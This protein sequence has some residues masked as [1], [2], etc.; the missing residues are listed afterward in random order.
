MS[1]FK[2]RTVCGILSLLLILG[3]L[4]VFLV[5][6]TGE[7]QGTG[8]ESTA[9][10]NQY[11]QGNGFF[12]YTETAFLFYAP[13]TPVQF[14]DTELTQPPE[15][16]CAKPNCRHNSV[17]CSAYVDTTGLYAYNNRLYYVTKGT[18]G[19]VGLYQMEFGG[20][21][22]RLLFS[23]NE[24][25]ELESYGYTYRIASG[26]FLLDLQRDSAFQSIDT[27]YLYPL[28][29]DK[30]APITIYEESGEEELVQFWLRNDW[31]FY[32]VALDSGEEQ[33]YLYGYQIST[34]HTTLLYEDWRIRNGLCLKGETLYFSK[35]AETLCGLELESGKVTEFPNRLEQVGENY[36]VIYDD[37]YCYLTSGGSA[38]LPG[39]AGVFIYTYEGELV[40]FIPFEG[41]QI[42]AYCISGPNVVLFYDAMSG[43][44]TPVCY[45]RKTDIAKSEAEF[46]FLE[47]QKHG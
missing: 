37:A 10:Y 40:Q 34:Q 42:L 39:K 19:D 32:T 38:N 12:S 33:Q 20:G 11:T 23:I 31:V 17:D 9:D 26:Y 4:C 27:L 16:M 44:N 41:N 22:R 7:A 46:I 8:T 5:S 2:Q 36:N 21:N 1:M 35:E 30:T 14:I 3:T 43:E 24:I 13:R 15:V 6:C 29:A 47:E 45:L 18:D 25:N 28:E